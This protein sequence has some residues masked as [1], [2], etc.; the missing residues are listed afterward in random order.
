MSWVDKVT[1]RSFVSV[2]VNVG[3]RLLIGASVRKQFANQV[4]I[5]LI[6]QLINGISRVLQKLHK[7]FNGTI[8]LTSFMS[9]FLVLPAIFDLNLNEAL[10]LL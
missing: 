9:L 2:I 7:D 8:I 5:R 3:T 6:L 4:R 10:L 1:T